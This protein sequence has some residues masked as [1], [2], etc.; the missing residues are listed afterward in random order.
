MSSLHV[1]PESQRV[2]WPPTAHKR[3]EL[4]AILGVCLEDLVFDEDLGLFMAELPT[5]TGA[6]EADLAVEMYFLTATSWAVYVLVFRL[7]HLASLSLAI[8]RFSSTPSILSAEYR[9]MLSNKVAGYLLYYSLEVLTTA[10]S[11]V[12]GQRHK[13]GRPLP[14]QPLPIHRSHIHPESS[15]SA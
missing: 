7:S 8:R 4:Y 11:S 5:A 12:S 2:F 6:V 1:H 3:C 9:H 13:H 15:R 10:T 14:S